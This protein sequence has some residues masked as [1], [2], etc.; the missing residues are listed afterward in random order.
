[1]PSRLDQS[2]TASPERGG[3]RLPL[4][5]Y[6]GLS[7]AVIAPALRAPLRLTIGHADSDI[8]KHLWH[9]WLVRDG[10]GEGMIGCYRIPWLAAPEGA[11]L[12][13]A[14]L[15]NNVAVL[16]L[17][18]LSIPLAIHVLIAAQLVAAAVAANLVARRLTGNRTA[19]LL[20]GCAYAFS[21]AVLFH[22]VASG[23]HE[24]LHLALPAL[25]LWLAL[26]FRDEGRWRDLIL[27]TGALCVLALA[28]PA[29]SV[30]LGLAMVLVAPVDVALAAHGERT[31]GRPRAALRWLAAGLCALATFAAVGWLT[32]RCVAEESHGGR[33]FGGDPD[34]L[35]PWP[36][37]TA[38]EDVAG[39][40]ETLP[41]ECFL[42]PR[43]LDACASRD[44]DFLYRYPYPGYVL[45]VLAAAGVVLGRRRRSRALA[46]L[47]FVVLL[48]SLGPVLRWHADDSA[49]WVAH[50]TLWL[51]RLVPF[52]HRTHVW[53]LVP[54]AQLLLAVGA[55][56]LLATRVPTTWR[57][58]AVAGAV[59]L[60][61]GETALVG[62]SA[63]P[64]PVTDTRIPAIYETLID[65]T[66]VARAPE[67]I[68]LDLPSHAREP[69]IGGGRYLW[70]QTAH[71]RAVPYAINPGR[72]EDDPLVGYV[73]DG[74][75][76][77]SGA[78]EALGR[79][80]TDGADHVV[81]HLGHASDEEEQRVIELM[82]AV[83]ARRIHGEDERLLYELPDYSAAGGGAAAPG[84]GAGSPPAGG[85]A[86]GSP[87]G[88]GSASP[89]GG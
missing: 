64:L 87:G 3:W 40:M 7:L 51:A 17:S 36:S 33:G 55:V 24:R 48:I 9:H 20:A 10:L 53:Q 58:F 80:I 81:L 84:V 62:R 52:V 15:V 22:P 31:A 2:A 41:L 32:S 45:M 43:A 13:D 26:R 66:G 59:I 57:H 70:Y 5:V 67:S 42:S 77:L 73:E 37:V 38:P 56:E 78:R 14:D 83:G 16:P 54:L 28:S 30:F 50:P 25:G 71:Q 75:G 47:G 60:V 18:V 86:P 35:S 29:Y 21:C 34:S 19:A 49:Y 76:G 65:H 4:A 74:R 27:F 8:W 39:K 69:R 85:A 89:G 6:T 72:F 61:L 1:M 82:Q 79:W 12:L 68:L 23:V 46:A 11:C 88:A 44:V 63:L